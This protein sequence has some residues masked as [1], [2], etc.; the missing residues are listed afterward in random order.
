MVVTINELIVQF[1]KSFERL[2]GHDFCTPNM[3][4]ACHL[5]DNLFDCGPLA[6]FWAFSFECYNGKLEG[7]KMLWYGLEMQMFK[8]FLAL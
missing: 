2:C 5:R 1:C 3:R 8:K 4:M 7:T 6:A